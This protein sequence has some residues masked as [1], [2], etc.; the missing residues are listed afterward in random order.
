[1][2]R[3]RE[4]KQHGSG[5]REREEGRGLLKESLSLPQ[6][7]NL[8]KAYPCVAITTKHS[9]YAYDGEP[10]LLLWANAG[11]VHNIV[12]ATSHGIHAP[13]SRCR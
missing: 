7:N 3:E 5:N 8:P 12:L 1:M 10:L 13:P 6:V 4:T 9:T 2:G 11:L